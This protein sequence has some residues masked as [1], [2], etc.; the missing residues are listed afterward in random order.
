MLCFV[1]EHEHAKHAAQTAAECGEEEQ[2]SFR[3]AVSVL[4][5]AALI[6]THEGKEHKAHEKQIEKKDAHFL[7]IP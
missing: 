2:R 3:H 1:V 7:K 6:R 4:L 5:C